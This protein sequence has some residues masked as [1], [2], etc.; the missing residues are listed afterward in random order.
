MSI[1]GLTDGGAIPAL[2]AMARF[3]AARQRLIADNVANL[4]TPGY[5]PLD[6]DPKAFQEQI[7]RAIDAR[8]SDPVAAGSGPLTL[9]N[10]G[11][12]RQLRGGEVVLDAAALNE[13]LMFHDKNDRNLERI[14]Q[15]LVQNFLVFRTT[16]ELLQNRFDILN[17]AIR[18]RI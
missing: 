2:E 1:Q 12:M 10:R 16:S 18:G 8:R 17:T 4:D 6:A 11:P 7:G 5:Q 15:D 3:S 9:Q 13:N 14:M